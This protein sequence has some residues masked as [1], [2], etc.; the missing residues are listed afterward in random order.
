[1]KRL[2]PLI[3]GLLAFGCSMPPPTSTAAIEKEPTRLYWGDTRLPSDASTKTDPALDFVVVAGAADSGTAE[4]AKRVWLETIEAAKADNETCVFTSF[5][6]WESSSGG[7]VFMNGGAQQ[8]SQLTPFDSADSANPEDLKAWLEETR[9]RVGTD[10]VIVPYEEPETDT[11]SQSSQVGFRGLVGVWA[12]E[13]TR[14]SIF[15]A[16]QRQE[17]YATTGPRIR[18]RFFGGWGFDA[19]SAKGPGMV[20][21]GYTL[22]HPMGSELGKA[23]EDKAPG[24]LMYAVKDPDGVNLDR[25]EIVKSWVDA[26]GTAQEKVYVAVKPAV[27]KPKKKK[28]K[29]DEAPPATTPVEPGAAA[30]SGFWSDPH[31]DPK[32]GASYYMRVLQVATPNDASEGAQAYT[33]P[34]AY[35]P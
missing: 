19:K 8:A 29:K 24:F 11:D 13:N 9:Q 31:F 12:V 34:I 6:G 1:M 17:V 33:S 23:P 7:V 18:A 21:T 32:V 28:K 30:L 10:F 2:T 16:F 15:A 5:I 27:E 14:T 22:G 25:I 35:T 3:V 26:D 4:T 20:N